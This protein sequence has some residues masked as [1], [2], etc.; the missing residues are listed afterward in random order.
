MKCFRSLYLREKSIPVIPPFGYR[1]RNLQSKK[2]LP[3]MKYKEH[4]EKDVSIHTAQNGDEI[5]FGR[6]KVDGYDK[7][8][9]QLMNF[10]HVNGTDI[11]VLSKVVMF[12]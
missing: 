7:K 2:A 8:T 12:P 3:W 5:Q 1:Q 10:M 6:F 11:P 9:I 4:I